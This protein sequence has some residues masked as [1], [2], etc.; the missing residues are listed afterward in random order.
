VLYAGEP[1]LEVLED[2]SHRTVSAGVNQ[3]RISG[4][5]LDVTNKLGPLLVELREQVECGTINPY[6]DAVLMDSAVVMK[7]ISRRDRGGMRV[8]DVAAVMNALLTI[9]KR[10]TQ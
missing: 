7:E 10:S 5:L 3:A 9:A 6:R 8:K 4:M 2:G 1:M